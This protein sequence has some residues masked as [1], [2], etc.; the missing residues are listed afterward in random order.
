MCKKLN[1]TEPNCLVETWLKI[2]EARTEKVTIDGIERY[3]TPLLQIHDAPKLKA[4]MHATMPNLRSTEQRLPTD[5]EKT[6]IY[7]EEILKLEKAGYVKKISPEI[8][9]ISG[10]VITSPW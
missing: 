4:L 3:A 6:A 7:N 8:V 5:Q 10:L 1:W 9:N 2:L